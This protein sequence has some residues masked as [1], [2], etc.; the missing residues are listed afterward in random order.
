MY[1]VI[2]TIDC[3]WR[4]LFIDPWDNFDSKFSKHFVFLS[5][6]IFVYLGIIIPLFSHTF[7][8]LIQGFNFIF[9]FIKILYQRCSLFI[10]CFS[11]KRNYSV[12]LPKFSFISSSSF[13]WSLRP[14]I[15]SFRV[16]LRFFFSL[17]SFI[18]D[19]LCS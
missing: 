15:S 5:K 16:S 17:R 10:V 1:K 18:K 8:F 2:T 4:Y 19:A 14:L 9:F 7:D 12:F 13:H 6:F 3:V 11:L